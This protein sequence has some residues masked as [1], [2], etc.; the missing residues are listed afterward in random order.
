VQKLQINVMDLCSSW[1]V[2]VAYRPK[3]SLSD[4]AG[5]PTLNGAV[6]FVSIDPLTVKG[7]VC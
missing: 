3:S 4:G 6:E 2:V 1:I 7:I 5:H